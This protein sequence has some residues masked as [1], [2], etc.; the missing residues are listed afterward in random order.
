MRAKIIECINAGLLFTVEMSA[1]IGIRSSTI[2]ACLNYMR[3]IGQV[4]STKVIDRKRGGIVNRWA[5]GPTLDKYGQPV[6]LHVRKIKQTRSDVPV[7]V[8][9]KSYPPIGKRDPLVA[10]LFGAPASQERTHP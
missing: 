9:S 3:Q 7:V 10:A 1:E 2:S 6:Q 8:M 4:H 5:V